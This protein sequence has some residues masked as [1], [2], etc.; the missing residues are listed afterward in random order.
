[1]FETVGNQSYSCLI[2]M[3]KNDKMTDQDIITEILLGNRFLFSKLIDKYQRMVFTLAMGFVHQKEN[4]ED[5]T[6]DIFI[7]VW[8]AL[9]NYKGDAIFSTW[10]Y[11]IAV[12]YCINFVEKNKRNRFIVLAEELIGH[13]F[14]TAINDKDAQQELE[15]MESGNLV[16]TAID[17]LPI[18]QRTAFILSAYEELPIK[19]IASIMNRSEGAVEQLLQRAKMNLKKKI[20]HP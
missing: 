18:N 10:L 17:S 11:R 6:Q 4:A 1:M 16:R 14:N 3:I 15:E 2:N 8:I 5:L 19:E 9:P 12:N 13:V 20:K 7:K